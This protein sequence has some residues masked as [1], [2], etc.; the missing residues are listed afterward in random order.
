MWWLL[1]ACSSPVE[2]DSDVRPDTGVE[3]SDS[4]LADDSAADSGASDSDARDTD[5]RDTDAL[6]SDASDSD[7][8]GTGDPGEPEL[9]PD[10]LL[11]DVN[12]T[13]SRYGEAVSPRD[14]I[15]KVAGFY[16]T[17]AT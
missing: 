6:D 16:F 15:G 9:A 7:D 1:V 5:A 17:H 10:F 8:P 12:P 11:D 2:T 4:D 13:S 3:V 14:Y